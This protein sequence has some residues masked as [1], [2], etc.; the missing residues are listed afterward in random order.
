MIIGML[1]E[2]HNRENINF[3]IKRSSIFLVNQI[4]ELEPCLAMSLECATESGQECGLKNNQF[5][6]T[7]I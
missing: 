6:M 7:V 5:K 2:Q 4:Y 1:R 3:R